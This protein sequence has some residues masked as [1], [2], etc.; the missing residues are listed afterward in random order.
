M[1]DNTLSS[2]KITNAQRLLVFLLESKH[3]GIELTKIKEITDLI[4]TTRLPGSRDYV[5]GLGNLRGEIIP[6]ISL[7]E[8]LHIGG[9]ECGKQL[10]VV[11]GKE[12]NYGLLIDKIQG[13]YSAYIEGSKSMGSIFS[14]DIETAFLKGICRIAEQDIILLDSDKLIEYN[15]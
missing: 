3:F 7:R 11:F 12:I 13:I 1:M 15:E 10:I 2:E 9:N 6:I 8:R 5:K 4:P 14:Q